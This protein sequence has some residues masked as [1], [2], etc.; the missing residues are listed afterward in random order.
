MSSFGVLRSVALVRTEISEECS[1]YIIK[2]T[3]IDLLSSPILVTLMLEALRCSET[4]VLTKAT[5][6]NIPLDNILHSHRRENLKSY[7][8]YLLMLQ[9]KITM[10]TL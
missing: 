8:C 1:T 10:D 5:W 4:L 7:K 2:V 9:N 3:R 6:H